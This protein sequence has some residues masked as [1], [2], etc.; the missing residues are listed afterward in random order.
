MGVPMV[1]T[2]GGLFGDLFRNSM[3]HL[4]QDQFIPQ[5]FSSRNMFGIGEQLI[6]K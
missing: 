5:K 6:N 2:S 1:S 4:G 3:F